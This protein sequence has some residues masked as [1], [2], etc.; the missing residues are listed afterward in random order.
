MSLVSDPCPLGVFRLL[1]DAPNATPRFKT[2]IADIG[3]AGGKRASCML[4][5]AAD[6]RRSTK[7]H[8]LSVGV[9]LLP[10]L[11]AHDSTARNVVAAVAESCR[12]GGGD[13]RFRP[14]RREHPCGIAGPQHLLDCRCAGLDGQLICP[15]AGLVRANPKALRNPLLSRC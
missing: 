12:L 9:D 1:K 3:D 14:S 15:A 10:A 11:E 4:S 8:V 6:A 13:A 7:L 5:F 2:Q